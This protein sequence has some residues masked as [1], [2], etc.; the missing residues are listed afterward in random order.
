MGK[1]KVGGYDVSA[2]NQMPVDRRDVD[3]PNGD[4]LPTDFSPTQIWPQGAKSSKIDHLNMKVKSKLCVLM[5][6][7]PSILLL[8]L[9]RKPSKSLDKTHSISLH[10]S[11]N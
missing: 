6:E 7:L 11:I 2:P 10:L 3:F 4:V 1:R 8:L 9:W 5:Q